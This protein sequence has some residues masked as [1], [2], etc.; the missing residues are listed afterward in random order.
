MSVLKLI[1]DVSSQI[2]FGDMIWDKMPDKNC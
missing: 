1:N 2:W